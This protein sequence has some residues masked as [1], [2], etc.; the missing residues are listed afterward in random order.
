MVWATT[1]SINQRS[2]VASTALAAVSAAAVARGDSAV[3]DYDG[4][5]TTAHAQVVEALAQRDITEESVT[6]TTGVA[7]AETDLTLALLFE[8]AQQIARDGSGDQ[9]AQ[10]AAF[11]RKSYEEEIA[12]VQPVDNVKGSGMGFR[13]QRG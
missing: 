11:F 1:A 6:R 8:S 7:R 13:W 12:R 3:T 2:I 5:I 9:Y 10:Q 4:L